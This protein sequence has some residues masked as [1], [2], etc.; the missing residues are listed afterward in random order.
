MKS[1]SFN[2]LVGLKYE[3]Y[4][5]LF[6]K[7]PFPFL[8]EIGIKLPLFAE[9][10]QTSLIQ[11]KSPTFIVKSFFSDILKTE[12]FEKQMRVLFLFSQFIERQ[13]VLFDALEQAA[14]TEIHEK[15][16]TG[17]VSYLLKRAKEETSISGISKTLENYHTR[18]VLTAHPTQFY[19][20][21]VLSIIDEFAVAIKK[22]DL[23]AIEQILLQLGMT[24]FRNE[25]A[26][27]PLNEAQYLLD[28]VRDVFYKTMLDLEKQL[29]DNLGDI[30]PKHS[31]V[32]LGFW[33]GGDR[34]GNPYVNVE[35]TYKV[36]EELRQCTLEHYQN[37]LKSL[38]KR[39][40]F[41]GI[42]QELNQIEER[43][44][45]YR[46]PQEL[47]EDINMLHEHI[48]QKHQ[49]LFL[50][51]IEHFQLA[52]RTFGF[53]FA[54]LDLRQD[55][56]VHEEVIAGLLQ[57]LGPQMNWP[58]ECK[59]YEQLDPT[60]KIE[61]LEKLCSVPPPA[62][63]TPSLKTHPLAEDLIESLKAI[64]VIQKANGPNGLHRYIISH[65]QGAQHLLEINFLLHLLQ[66]DDIELDIVPL[67]ETIDDLK[68]SD[69]ALKQLYE[70]PVYH[71]HL[72]KRGKKQTVMV[73]FSDGTKD[74]GYL[75]CNWEIFKAKQRLEKLSADFGIRIVF[76]DGRGGP[77]AR[78]GGNTHKFY[79]AL[80][81]TLEQH[82]V[83][84][85]IQGQ[86]VSS[87]FG[88]Y[89]SAKSNLEQI[90][91][92]GAEG[93][94]FNEEKYLL[95]KGG[96]NLIDELSD[97]SH[98][99]YIDLRNHPLF[100][101]FLQEMTPLKY[102][103]KLNVASRP[104]KRGEKK[105]LLLQDLRAI[106]FVGAWSQIKLN[107]PGFYGLG[108][109]LK[110]AFDTGRGLEIKRLYQEKLFFSTLINNAMQALK[111]SNPLYTKHLLNNSTYR[112]LV[113]IIHTELESAK[114]FLLKASGQSE[115]METDPIN[116]QS[117]EM[118]EKVISPLILI[119][120]YAMEN[121]KNCEDSKQ[122]AAYEKL[123][124]KSLPSITN[125]S[126]NS[127]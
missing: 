8:E 76:F 68:N 64:K 75:T 66:L 33:P 25:K 117:I 39:L 47:L 1:H 101:P 103:G 116:R 35:T 36:A 102:F 98:H 110:W 81:T 6:L 48:L 56:S 90:F 14:F 69:K 89:E 59:N 82:E 42:I 21:T 99:A 50:E 31:M 12:D 10:C 24:S 2:K 92:A 54:S 126:R 41:P 61:L 124:M 109:A 60:T 96:V 87:K 37:E 30:R 122:Q 113:K 46:N 95:N 67:F 63:E 106:P 84:L 40:T 120:Q 51:N 104:S 27:T 7:L 107:I 115:L 3:L 26:P 73:G 91:T 38:K 57:K 114:Y 58:Q 77:P 74:G 93:H 34:D 121:L 70:S 108:I 49:G 62:L 55:S 119:Q 13:V 71:K 4:N 19:P 100:L 85:T 123:I 44:A 78:G 16:E 15:E 125:A 45:S 94:L 105:E 9:R 53:H 80:G 29:D 97:R 32:E 65:S 17:S 5:G 28:R 43:L 86:T 88:T 23:L 79:K 18:I 72:Q 83:Q 20:E 52:V 118:R 127:A 11:G 112:P 22:N 111:K